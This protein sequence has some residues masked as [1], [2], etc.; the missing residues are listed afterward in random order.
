MRSVSEMYGPRSRSLTYSVL[1]SRDA[2]LDQLLDAGGGQHLVGLGD[3]LAGLGVDDVVRQDLA[4]Q[5]LARHRQLLHARVLE[6]AH[7]ARGDAAA[8]LDDDLVADADLEARGLA[9]QALRHQL[10]RRRCRRARSKVFF[11]KNV[12]ST[13]VSVMPS[14]RRMIDD[15]QLAAAVDAREHAVLRV[16]LEVEPRAA[17]GNDARARTAACRTNASCRGRGRRTRPGERCSCETMTRSVPLTM[18]V[19]LSVISG[20]SPR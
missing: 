9:A 8:F 16:E 5:V 4:V 12:S 18:K 2:G 14:A 1:I 17:V 3:D 19:P 11:S 6:L 20:S 7:V 10:H 13:S 15:R